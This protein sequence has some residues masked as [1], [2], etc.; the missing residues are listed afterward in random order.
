VP[1]KTVAYA[2]LVFVL[3]IE[4]LIRIL[5]LAGVTLIAILLKINVVRL[6]IPRGMPTF[7]RG[8]SAHARMV[9]TPRAGRR[10]KRDGLFARPSSRFYQPTLAAEHLLVVRPH[11]LHH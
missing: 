9:L 7:R 4:L 10:Q 3:A 1:R 2:L 6:F 11:D 5:G 8:A